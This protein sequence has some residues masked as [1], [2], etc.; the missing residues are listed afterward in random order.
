VASSVAEEELEG[1]G[2]RLRLKRKQR[3]ALVV[4][5]LDALLLE[6]AADGVEL[7][8]LEPALIEDL[9][10]RAPPERARLLGSLE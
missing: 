7:E 3:Q 5:D 2:R 8:Q 10:D 1:V 4:D 6:L 9:R